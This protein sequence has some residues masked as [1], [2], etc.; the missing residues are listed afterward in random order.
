MHRMIK[1]SS[2]SFRGTKTQLLENS[3]APMKEFLLNMKSVQD[4]KVPQVSGFTC[5]FCRAQLQVGNIFN[6]LISLCA[7]PGCKLGFC[8]GLLASSV[9]SFWEYQICKSNE[10]PKFT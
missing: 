5:F 4:V 3:H 2:E 8:S 10:T 7:G 1:G 6:L 9:F